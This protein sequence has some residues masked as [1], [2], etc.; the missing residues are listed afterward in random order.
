[1]INSSTSGAGSA[2]DSQKLIPTSEAEPCLVCGNTTGHDSFSEDRS[3][4]LC[5]NYPSSKGLEVNGYRSIGQTKGGQWGEFVLV[6]KLGQKT[7]AKRVSNT[8]V[9]QEKSKE[10]SLADLSPGQIRFLCQIRDNYF[11]KNYSGKP[12][13]P[14]DLADLIRRG[15]TDREIE[16]FGAVSVEGK[17]PGYVYPIFSPEGLVIGAAKRLRNPVN[18][19]YKWVFLA[20]S[21]KLQD[22]LPL[23]Y[24]RP[25]TEKPTGIA[26][27]E[28]T[29]TKSFILANKSGK[30]TIGAGA[31]VQF[32]N[33]TTIW[34][35]FLEAAS[36]ETGSKVID[37]FPDSG[38]VKN[39]SVFDNY[40]K[41]FEFAA[42]LGYS[43]RIAWWNQIEKGADVD[44]LTADE[45][46]AIDFIE[47]SEFEAIA[48]EYLPEPEPER[49]FTVDYFQIGLDGKPIE[50]KSNEREGIRKLEVPTHGAFTQYFLGKFSGK[51]GRVDDLIYL[52]NQGTGLFELQSPADLKAQIVSICKNNSIT[53]YFD[54]EKKHWIRNIECSID[55]QISTSWLDS[56][57]KQI[58][59]LA[60]PIKLNQPDRSVLAL[61]NGVLDL[62][63]FDLSSFEA[64]RERGNCFTYKSMISYC[65]MAVAP[66][67]DRFLSESVD[68]RDIPK[69]QAAFTETLYRR[70]LKY[71]VEVTGAHNSG[72]TIIQ[73]ILL[74]LF[75]DQSS[76]VC[77]AVSL[78]KLL[79]PE[80]KHATATLVG[81]RLVLVPD[82]KGYVGDC[83]ILKQITSGG[84][85]Q[86]FERKNKDSQ[87]FVFEGVVWAFGNDPLRFTN[88][89]PARLSR[90]VGVHCPNTIA[91]D[92]RE[93]L[94]V[95]QHGKAVGAFVPQ[96]SGILNWILAAK[97]TAVQTLKAIS[98]ASVSES[99]LDCPLGRWA[100]ENIALG[101]GLSTSVGKA[102]SEGSLYWS[103]H[104]WCKNTNHKSLSV[105]E[106]QKGFIALAS[107]Q[108]VVTVS[109]RFDPQ[110]RRSFIEGVALVQTPDSG[111]DRAAL[112]YG[113]DLKG[114]YLLPREETQPEPEQIESTI[115]ADSE[116]LQGS[117]QWQPSIGD[118]VEYCD[119]ED[120]WNPAKI[121]SLPSLRFSGYRL[122]LLD[123]SS[124]YVASIDQLRPNRDWPLVAA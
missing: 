111:I 78:R 22:E 51:I 25:A 40:Q 54:S 16:A 73:K 8:Q 83:D 121:D 109:Q 77:T 37:F 13:H 23:S 47:V 98:A 76:P 69:L 123:G 81:K 93:D 116:T 87:D 71:Y 2:S 14:D 63:T 55:C 115:I 41:F 28:G 110:L 118:F 100:S 45:F 42:S 26:I 74:A 52:A 53:S 4:V 20:G 96:L 65:P 68:P 46:E 59:A 104:N 49:F 58:R 72:K 85:R 15:L 102:D 62:E 82:T 92:K 122:R 64:E 30:I 79:N 89:D 91:I 113:R 33:S 94:F 48:K 114:N 66:R 1:M 17:E 10:T 19:R 67:W 90:K 34:K 38:S 106:F 11:R 5:H 108:K 105:S 99:N 119:S 61:A 21:S 31:A 35:W 107:E 56:V 112:E 39:S 44:D 57:E 103:Y 60:P 24:Q 9:K 84:D 124:T 80:N 101:E 43:I 32:A 75:G 50:I 6:A 95:W 18:G 3:F 120:N 117:G 27:V 36:E 97:D 12:L 7:S 29:G 86:E 88:D 70:H